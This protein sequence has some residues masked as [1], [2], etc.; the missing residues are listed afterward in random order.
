MKRLLTSSGLRNAA[1]D[2][3]D[4]AQVDVVSDGRWRLHPH[5]ATTRS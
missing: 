5:D 2:D 4:G 1:G 3:V